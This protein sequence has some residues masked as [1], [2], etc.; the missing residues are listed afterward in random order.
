MA[1]STLTAT[2]SLSY[3]DADGVA[4]SSSVV[5]AAPYQAM[6]EG[7]LDVPNGLGSAQA[8]TIPFGTIAK[9][10]GFWVS[11]KTAN[12]V[13]P[14]QDLTLKINGGAAIIDIAPGGEVFYAAP[15]FSAG[16]VFA[17]A[18]LTTTASQTGNGAIGFRVYGDPV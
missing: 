5:V 12:G 7:T 4:K 9:A 6:T 18:T 16:N 8:L 17:S 11:N 15:A 13:N 3:T 10:T 14:G 2:L 1:N